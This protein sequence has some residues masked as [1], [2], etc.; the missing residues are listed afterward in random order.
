METLNVIRGAIAVGWYGIQTY[1]TSHALV[2]LSRRSFPPWRPYAD[3][4]HYG[5][6]GL[7]ALGWLIRRHVAAPG[8]GVLEW[9]GNDQEIRRFRWAGRLFGDVLLTD[10]MLY[11]GGTQGLKLNLTDVKYHDWNALPMMI[12]AIALAAGYYAGPVLNFGDLPAIVGRTRL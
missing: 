1:L 6:L 7:S 10:W 5:Y 9:H 4:D 8:G 2:V 12:T 3:K 11:K